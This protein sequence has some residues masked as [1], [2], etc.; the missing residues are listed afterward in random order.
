MRGGS[1]HEQLANGPL[2][3]ALVARLGDQ[4]G[5]ALALAHRHGV[6]HRDLK[7]A[8]ILRDGDG[9]YYLADFGI[10]KDLAQPG[11]PDSTV[12]GALL[13]SPAYLAPEQI[14]D[15]PVGLQSDL[16]SL[17]IVLYEVLTGRAPFI[18]TTR[19]DLFTQHLYTPVPA[20]TAVRPDLPAGL[21][22]VIARATAKV[23]TDRYPDVAALLVD[24]RQALAGA[25]GCPPPVELIGT[26]GTSHMT[27][28]SPLSPCESVAT[29]LLHRDA[30]VATS[31][32][33][34][35]LSP[36]VASVNSCGRTAV[37][38]GAQRARAIR[39]PRELPHYPARLYR[40]R[41]R[42]AL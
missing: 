8:N 25:I 19:I 39:M 21:D 24:L 9:N 10:A 2:P 33:D 18:G 38:P 15:E 36:A 13:G 28:V 35:P 26:A 17:G 5:A 14:R 29:P 16:Y 12:A 40:E 31:S 1:L 34:L 7:P 20:L 32:P 27:G 41:A 30:L 37:D 6:V 11:G 3:L 4:L 23:P 22:A 42:R